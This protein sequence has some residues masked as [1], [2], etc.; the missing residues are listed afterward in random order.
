MVGPRIALVFLGILVVG[1]GCVVPLEERLESERPRERVGAVYELAQRGDANAVRRMIP[2]LVDDDEGVRFYAAVALRRATGKDFGYRAQGPLA[3]RARVV[4]RWV[5][6]FV[7]EHPESEAGFEPLRETLRAMGA[8][9]EA[10]E[11]AR[12]GSG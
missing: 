10:A 6:W 9:P 2:L 5:D 8:E 4:R 11:P 12:E 1:A 7:A 3:E